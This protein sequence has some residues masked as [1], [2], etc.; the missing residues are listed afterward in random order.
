M[1]DWAM[2]L[3]FFLFFSFANQDVTYLFLYSHSDAGKLF[4]VDTIPKLVKDP[5]ALALRSFAQVCYVTWH[6]NLFQMI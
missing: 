6:Q 5:A 4:M 2:W 3:L 1:Q